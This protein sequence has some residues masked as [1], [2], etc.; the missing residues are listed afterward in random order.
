VA[1]TPITGFDLIQLV[2]AG[3]AAEAAS[4]WHEP[5]GYWHASALMMCPRRNVLWQAGYATDGNARSG[6]MNFQ[7]GH[8]IHE[9]IETWAHHYQSVEPRFELVNVE[10]QDCRTGEFIVGKRDD[11]KLKAR[12]DFIFRWEGELVIAEI[13]SERSECPICKKGGAKQYRV[14][15]AHDEGLP[16]P[17][18]KEHWVQGVA[19]AMCYEEHYGPIKQGRAFYWGKND[20]LL[21]SV[22]FSTDAPSIRQWIVDRCKYLTNL[23]YA[24]TK[25]GELPARISPG[26]RDDWQC[27][28]RGVRDSDDPSKGETDPRGLYCPARVVC[29][30][31]NA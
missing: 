20:Y 31:S 24:F 4:E 15:E 2:D 27:R 9:R 26:T 6:A 23:H 30:A 12:P 11:I 8:A 22:P 1:V 29:Y 16:T 13:K 21:E 3:L 25:L 28:P 10:G 14:K 7:L 17:I 18:K 19:S 5:D